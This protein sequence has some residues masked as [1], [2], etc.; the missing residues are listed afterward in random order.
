MV[1]SIKIRRRGGGSFTLAAPTDSE[2]KGH[3][4]NPD[5][6]DQVATITSYWRAS[7][8]PPQARQP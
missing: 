1:R 6:G 3:H 7:T 5:F 8:R 2:K 4:S